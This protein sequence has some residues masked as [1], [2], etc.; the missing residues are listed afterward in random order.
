MTLEIKTSIDF[1]GCKADAFEVRR[2]V[3]MEEQ[4]YENEFE[5][6]DDDPRCIHVTGYAQGELVGC[7][8]VFPEELER[9]LSPEV[10]Q[11]PAY[12]LDEQVD[13]SQTYLMGRVAV[14]APARRQGFALALVRAA[15]EAARAAGAQLMKLHA[16]AY[17][18]GMY[19]QLGYE[20]IRDVDYEDEGQP[21]VW[22][23][24]LL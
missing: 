6:I 17:I 15:E 12:P 7:A 14:V 1:A 19:E 9:T 5:A 4:G 24:K 23:A 8:R 21:H 10:P 20:A 22:M 3:F 11:S 2:I 16:Q 18:R 13:A